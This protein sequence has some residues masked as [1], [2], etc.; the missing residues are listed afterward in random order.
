MISTSHDPRSVANAI[1][2]SAD[3]RAI[4]LT[5]LSIQK[6]LYFAHASALA[7]YGKPLVKGV[8]EAWEFGP[9]CRPVYDALKQY[10]SRPVTEL[11]ER[12]DPI[13]GE[14]SVVKPPE[15]W[16]VLE[17]IDDVLKSIGHLSPGQLVDL[18]HAPNGAWEEVWNKSKSSPT[19]GNRIH[20]K[21]SAERFAFLKMPV[22]ESS[23]FGDVDEATP[24]TGD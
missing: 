11:I 21:L 24:I 6:L 2:A 9:V 16:R 22:N 10:G 23:K 3:R 5:N 18:S 15:D 19:I 20:D 12:R 1:I 7:R 17:H 14:T 4:K 13:S 8:F